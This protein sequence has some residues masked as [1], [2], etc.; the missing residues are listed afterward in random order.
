MKKYD[1]TIDRA[2]AAMLRDGAVANYRIEDFAACFGIS[3]RT[4]WSLIATG[5]V[6]AIKAG[7][8]VLITAE[9]ARAWRERCPKVRPT[10]ASKR[11]DET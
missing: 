8:R 9:S 5:E 2:R 10:R 11:G 4:T 7:R 3:A 1:S 6:D